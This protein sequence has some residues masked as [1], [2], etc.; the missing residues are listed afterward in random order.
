MATDESAIAKP[1]EAGRG[2]QVL[3]ILL[4]VAFAGYLRFD[5]FGVRS[6]WLDEFSTW[7]VSRLDLG[8]SLRW[9]PERTIAPL[10]QLSLRLLSSDPH[11]SEW[12]L[13]FPAA[14]AGTLAVA[15][16]AL[17]GWRLGGFM[18]G[19][20]AALLL[21]FA[22]LQIEYS[23]EA[24]P[25]SMLV[26]GS[27]V[28][29][30]LW[31]RLLDKPRLAGWFAYVLV[32]LLCMHAHVLAVFLVLAQ[33]GWWIQRECQ[34]FDRRRAFFA[35]TA[36]ATTA[37]LCMPL[38][39]RAI[40]ARDTVSNA[41]DWIAPAGVAGALTELA[42][43]TFGLTWLIILAV[44]V[45]MLLAA[46]MLRTRISRLA[47]DDA[48]HECAPGGLALAAWWLGGTWLG[49]VVVSILFHPLLIT[50]YV[51]PAAAPALLLPL[52]ASRRLH[53]WA[54]PALA[55]ATLLV[56][57]PS[58][59]GAVARPPLGFR[60]L[61]QFLAERED[62]AQSL[63]VY[64]VDAVEP[65]FVEWESCAYRYYPI[66]GAEPRIWILHAPP[67]DATHDVLKDPRKLYVIAFQADPRL[68]IR[69]AGRSIELFPVAETNYTQRSFGGYTLCQ[70]APL[71]DANFPADH[72]HPTPPA[73]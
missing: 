35:L 5:G 70:V 17:L 47:S 29:V 40:L 69:T 9:A 52:L 1:R 50:R 59:I 41:L 32:T 8:E 43:V 14:C 53:R 16:L 46:G 22:P 23:Q 30:L 67:D 68:A 44:T 33:T 42:K 63:V 61:T 13:R 36:L 3:V 37:L 51:L 56:A 34:R 62:L 57:L 10:Y 72:S 48:Q 7:H 2:P 49:L 60:E 71:Q 27:I 20:S 21:A 39:L 15:A 11:P 18:V 64:A 38:A 58:Q 28:S 65:A 24:R 12:V 6:L 73:P 26:L 54:P 55:T 4:I 25:Y 19:V 66:P 45:V 31:E